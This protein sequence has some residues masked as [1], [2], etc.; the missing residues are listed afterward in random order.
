MEPRWQDR[1][2]ALQLVP[3]TF[4]LCTRASNS[5]MK[6]A[7]RTSKGNTLPQ[8][9]QHSGTLYESRS[10]PLLAHRGLSPPEERKPPPAVHEV[11]RVPV[12]QEGREMEAP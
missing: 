11:V 7:R 8:T 5:P 6:S 12:D 1:E 4:E 2:P 3:V 9:W 10:T